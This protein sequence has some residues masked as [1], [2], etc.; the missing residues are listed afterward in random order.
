[1]MRFGT[2][3]PA[4]GCWVGERDLVQLEGETPAEEQAL[5]DLAGRAGA[6]ALT[7]GLSLVGR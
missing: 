6:P 2:S 3:S 7:S 5:E 4:P 1:M